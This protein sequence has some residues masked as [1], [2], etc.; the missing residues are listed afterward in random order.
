MYLKYLFNLIITIAGKIGTAI[1]TVIELLINPRSKIKHK[2]PQHQSEHNAKHNVKQRYGVN[3]LSIAELYRAYI[4][5]L[6]SLES[7]LKMEL[8]I[9]MR[10]LGYEAFIQ[11]GKIYI[12]KNLALCVAKAIR[13]CAFAI[14]QNRQRGAQER[15]TLDFILD[16]GRSSITSIYLDIEETDK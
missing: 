3:V 6:E 7:K 13:L 5:P 11:V 8:N 10:N 1:S 14:I 9:E 12:K 2:R 4:N 15:T 16:A